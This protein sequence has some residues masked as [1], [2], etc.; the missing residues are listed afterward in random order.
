MAL[1][2]CLDERPGPVVA[3][4]SVVINLNATG[5]GDAILGALPNRCVIVEEVSREF[6][7]GRRTG[8]GDADAL[9]ALIEQQLVEHAQLGD[10]G[11]SHFADL[12]GGAAADTL[13]DGEAATIACA[14]ERSAIALIDDRKAIRLCAERFPHLAVGCTLDVLAQQH[15]QAAF[16]HRLVEA[17][18]NALDRGR[19]RVPE[20]YEQWVVNLIGRER[21]ALCRSLPKRIRAS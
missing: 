20:R 10:V 9:G 21:A 14:M 1:R 5:A 12:V 13:D 18:F 15:V 4:T 7:A 3:D 19:M 16:G 8:R 11:I 2:S 17:V 6:E